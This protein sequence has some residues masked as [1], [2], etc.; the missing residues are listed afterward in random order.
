MGADWLFNN[1]DIFAQM[2][3]KLKDTFAPA[4]ETTDATK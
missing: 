3:R 2:G 1:F 4:K